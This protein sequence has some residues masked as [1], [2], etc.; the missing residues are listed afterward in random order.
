AAGAA[1]V[2]ADL[3]GVDARDANFS[4]ADLSGA[5]LTGAR[6][7]GVIS[8]GATLAGLQADWLDASAEGDGSRRVPRDK[9]IAVL[10]REGPLEPTE[11]A[12]NRRYF[13]RGD[14][15]RN[16]TLEFDSGAFVEIE[17]LF[18][19]CS[20]SLGQ[21]T[22]LVVGRGGVLSDCQIK[23]GGNITINGHFF[24]RQSPGIIGAEQVVVS[25]GGALVGAVEQAA[26]S[27]RFA[28]EPGCKLRMKILQAKKTNGEG[29]RE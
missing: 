12:A 22:E 7:A 23:G 6:V 20:I 18:E 16:A 26:H 8:A 17:S 10:G 25:E 28:F 24:E 5:T 2:G 19:Q 3:S 21:G 29:R 13:G 11:G 15:L 1:L 4:K 27:T 9:V 14:V